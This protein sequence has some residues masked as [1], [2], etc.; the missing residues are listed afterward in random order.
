MSSADS[1]C[2]MV[3]MLVR[4][5]AESSAISAWMSSSAEPSMLALQKFKLNS[6][7]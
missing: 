7:M 2:L 6:G 5:V 1:F 3:M 4:Q